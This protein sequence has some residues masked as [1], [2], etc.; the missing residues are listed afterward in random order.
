MKPVYDL[1]E[2]LKVLLTQMKDWVFLG[3]KVALGLWGILF[4]GAVILDFRI[5][6]VTRT[7]T[8]LDKV[9]LEQI[10]FFVLLFVVFFAVLKK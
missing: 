4:V 8:V 3:F 5:G 2:G 9:G 10:Y 6:I 7:L 1:I